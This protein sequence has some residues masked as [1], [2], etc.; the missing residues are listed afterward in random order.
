MSSLTLVIPALLFLVIT[1]V[2][3][4]DGRVGTDDTFRV[5]RVV[6]VIGNNQAAG[7]H[8]GGFNGV[9]RMTAPGL[10]T[11]V[12]VSHLDELSIGEHSAYSRSV[13][14]AQGRTLRFTDHQRRKLG[15][16]SQG[17][18]TREQRRFNDSVFR[19]I[20]QSRSRIQFTDG[21]ELSA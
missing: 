1:S 16:Q 15:G 18:G 8:R 9:F 17:T 21:S 2:L 19:A 11:S 5:S 7:D 13:L 10:E 12:Y 6:C 14:P 3:A 4:Q 20:R